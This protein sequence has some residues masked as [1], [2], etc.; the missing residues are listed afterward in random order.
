MK[1]ST[2]T[3]VVGEWE[4]VANLAWRLSSCQNNLAVKQ[5]PKWFGG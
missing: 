2:L 4:K 5:S 3:L 1:R